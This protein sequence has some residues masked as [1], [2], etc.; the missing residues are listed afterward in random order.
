MMWKYSNKVFLLHYYTTLIFTCWNIGEEDL[1]AGRWGQELIQAANL[2]KKPSKYQEIN[3]RKNLKN[4]RMKPCWVQITFRS[5]HTIV[6]KSPKNTKTKHNLILPTSIM[7]VSNPDVSVTFLLALS[8]IKMQ[9]LGVSSFNL[10]EEDVYW[11]KS[12]H[13]LHKL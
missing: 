6:N 12:L 4:R 13:Y 3:L 8:I 9:N 11:N 10:C 5:F 7:C 1:S 2:V